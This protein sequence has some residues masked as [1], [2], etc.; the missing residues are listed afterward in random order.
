MNKS[1]SF[2]GER[3]TSDPVE[4]RT[5]KF[6]SKFPHNNLFSFRFVYYSK[7]SIKGVINER[8]VPLILNIHNS[9]IY[10]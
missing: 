3:F 7:R 8:C 6:P 9:S 2:N 1:Q 4:I 5:T 10:F